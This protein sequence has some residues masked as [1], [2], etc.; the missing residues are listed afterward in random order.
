MKHL[1]L[2]LMMTFAYQAYAQVKTRGGPDYH[3][4]DKKILSVSQI[5]SAKMKLKNLTNL[6]I[7]IE[8]DCTKR[9]TV[10]PKDYSFIDSYHTLSLQSFIQELQGPN[11]PFCVCDQEEL[12]K[13]CLSNI[14]LKQS[15]Y[16]LKRDEKVYDFILNKYDLDR[17]STDKI[18]NFFLT[19]EKK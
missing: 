10:I 9:K 2:I 18:Y 4:P 16:E 6:L 14:E 12:V 8:K 1:L 13:S 7:Q 5:A 11:H 19:P 3:R 15:L 17:Y